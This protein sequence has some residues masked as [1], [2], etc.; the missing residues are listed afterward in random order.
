MVDSMMSSSS[1]QLPAPAKLHGEYW[2]SSADL[3]Y[4][5]GFSSIPSSSSL[6]PMIAFLVKAVGGMFTNLGDQVGV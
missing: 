5:S 1:L 4:W 2:R 6:A 3:D